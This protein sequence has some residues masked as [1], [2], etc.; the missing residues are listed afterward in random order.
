MVDN[1]S[2]QYNFKTL[3][4]YLIRFCN[5]FPSTALNIGTPYNKIYYNVSNKTFYDN[6][7]D[8]ITELDER[9]IN[10]FLKYVRKL[11]GEM[12]TATQI[13]YHNGI[14]QNY[15]KDK[16]HYI[17]NVDIPDDNGNNY[18][19]WYDELGM[20][21]AYKIYSAMYYISN[22]NHLKKYLKYFN[23]FIK[24]FN[25][26]DANEIIKS[27]SGMSTQIFY[28]LLTYIFENNQ[29]PVSL[30]LNKAGFIGIKY[31][32][33]TKWKRPEGSSDN[34]MNYVVF[35]GNNTNIT[36]RETV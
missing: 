7:T 2:R 22:N 35:R 25:S 30:I 24:Y 11:E 8:P 17:Y 27:I 12:N 33:G 28:N 5:L 29:K 21:N 1:Y 9:I 31:P 19:S 3:L 6:N 4:S 32:T 23:Y 18:L 36:S 26:N 14:M 13:L 10:K 15:T 20:E 34:G 16:N